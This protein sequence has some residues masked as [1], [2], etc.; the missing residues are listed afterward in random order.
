MLKLLSI[1]AATLL[2]LTSSVFATDYKA[3]YEIVEPKQPTAAFKNCVSKIT[4]ISSFKHRYYIANTTS[5]NLTYGKLNRLNTAVVHCAKV[6][7]QSVK[8]KVHPTCYTENQPVDACR[9]YYHRMQ[10][11]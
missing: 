8:Y 4:G 1:S 7:G 10:H 3:T 6:H 2:L 9:K 11:G 5:I